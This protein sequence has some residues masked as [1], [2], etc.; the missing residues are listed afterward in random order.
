M[1]I[2]DIIVA[3]KKA[4]AKSVANNQGSENEGKFLGISGTGE[5]IPIEGDPTSATA[6]DVTYNPDATYSEGTV[7]AE[8]Q[9]IGPDVTQLKS[10]IA[11]LGLSVVDGKLCVTYTA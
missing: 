6:G 10:D 3:V 2:L 11:D 4:L 9:E 5:V 8:L 7:G 1:D